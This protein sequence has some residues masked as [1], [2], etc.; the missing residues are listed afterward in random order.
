MKKIY[1]QPE[2]QVENF[3]VEDIITDSLTDPV[4]GANGTPITPVN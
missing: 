3:E 1:S 2:L 4:P